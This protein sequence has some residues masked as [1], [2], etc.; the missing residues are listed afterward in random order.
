MA[1]F[2]SLCDKKIGFFSVSRSIKDGC[3]CDLC[4]NKFLKAIGEA[5]NDVWLDE[6]K[7]YTKDYMN[8]VISGN[9]KIET[10]RDIFKPTNTIA[11]LFVID[12]NNK[13][14]GFLQKCGEG[15][16]AEMKVCKI[17]K[18]E[19]IFDYEVIEDEETE[20]KQKGGAL[21]GVGKGLLGGMFF[22]GIGAL[23]GAASGNKKSKSK[24]IITSLKIVI[25]LKSSFNQVTIPIIETPTK[26]YQP[27]KDRCQEITVILDKIKQMN[28]NISNKNNND[29]SVD[30]VEE[31]RK[32]KKLLDE[33]I[34]TEEE[35]NQKKKQLLEK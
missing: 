23:A 9:E 6:I 32:Y 14:W 8:D 16:Y 13:L 10:F 1:K 28:E 11:D 31:I 4:S 33:G 22:G 5:G 15:F 20:T 21:S 30:S 19:D 18:F 25:S 2:C 12:E 7:Y 29:S 35:F 24:T 27:F 3:I 34:I 17:Y 26:N